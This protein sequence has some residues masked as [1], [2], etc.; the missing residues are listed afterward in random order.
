MNEVVIVEAIRTPI[1]AYKGSLKE[2]SALNSLRDPLYAPIGVLIASTITTSFIELF[3][4][5]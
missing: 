5:I 2:L 1:G 4:I 3:I